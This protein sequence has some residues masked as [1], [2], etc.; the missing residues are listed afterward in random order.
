MTHAAHAEKPGFI[1]WIS[2]WLFTT[3]HKDIGTLY[4]FFS[5]TMF[6]VGGFFA[7]IIR[8]KLSHPGQTWMRSCPRLSDSQTGCF[9]L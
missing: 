6:F 9:P 3:N 8:A 5:L 1:N 4:L 2:R 7:M